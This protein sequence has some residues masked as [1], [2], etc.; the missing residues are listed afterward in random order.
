MRRADRGAVE[1]AWSLASLLCP[2]C[3]LSLVRRDHLLS[4]AERHSFDIARQNYVNLVAAIGHRRSG[5][6][7]EMVENRVAFLRGEHFR[8][9]AALVGSMAMRAGTD[10]RVVVDAG[11]G[12]GYYLAHV[13]ARLPRAVG[14]VM[15]SSAAVLRHAGR[16]HPRAAAIG[17][18]VW[19]DWPLASASV[20]VVLNIFAPRNAAEFHRVLRPT[21]ALVIVTP[22][23]DHLIELRDATPL[24]TIDQR[25]QQR[26]RATIEPMFG[27]VDHEVLRRRLTLDESDQRRIVAMGPNAFH[28]TVGDVPFTPHGTVTAAFSVTRYH[29]LPVAGH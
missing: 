17:W 27:R 11:G 1:S 8:D 20:D 18:D 5:D 19:R 10:P 7:A 29:P 13:L 2:I 21:G 22:E 28:H 3:G 9:L 15:D 26:L 12:T 25:K 4:C 23:P 16:A 14:L 6:T 24:L